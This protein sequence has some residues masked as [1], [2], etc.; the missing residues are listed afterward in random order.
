MPKRKGRRKKGPTPRP[1]SGI[2]AHKRQGKTLTPPLK[3]LSNMKA[4]PWLRDTL[5]DMLWLCSNVW[6]DEA[7]KGMVVCAR[8]LDVIDDAIKESGEGEDLTQ[9][10]D[11]RLT[12]LDLVPESARILV[13]EKLQ[14]Q[15]NYEIAVPEKF[16]H[17]L[18]MYPEAPG[19]W[20]IEPWLQGDF[21][22]DW[23]VAQGFLSGLVTECN[24]GQAIVPTRAKFVAVSRWFKAGK[25]E[26]LAI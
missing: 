12:R 10:I 26:W 13:L 17:A 1:T 3:S 22:I 23:E 14:E 20:I 11:G 15:G 21:S 2:G 18:G 25:F 6:I 8:T 7:G 9:A 4:V 19:R 5:P 24:H 16:A